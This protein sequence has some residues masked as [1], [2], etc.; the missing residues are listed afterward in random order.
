MSWKYDQ[1]GIKYDRAG[2]LYD[3]GN[4]VYEFITTFRRRRR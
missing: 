2:L 4:A 3:L 1:P